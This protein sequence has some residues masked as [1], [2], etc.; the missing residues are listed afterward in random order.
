MLRYMVIWKSMTNNITIC[1]NTPALAHSEATMIKEQLVWPVMS[2]ITSDQ[3]AGSQVEVYND[4][5]RCGSLVSSVS[6]LV[7]VQKPAK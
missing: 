6:V 4:R 2:G 5:T 3:A 1:M 7:P